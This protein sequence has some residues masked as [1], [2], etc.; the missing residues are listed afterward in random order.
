VLQAFLFIL[1]AVIP[2]L[3][4]TAMVYE[5][6]FIGFNSARRHLQQRAIN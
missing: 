4:Q 1:L 2:T 3:L 5:Y 6:L